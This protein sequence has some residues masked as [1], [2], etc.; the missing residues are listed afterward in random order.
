MP[1]IEVDQEPVMFRARTVECKESLHIESADK[2]H[3]AGRQALRNV[4]SRGNLV[5]DPPSF[6]PKW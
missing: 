6:P 3:A 2:H 5:D 1:R 4:S